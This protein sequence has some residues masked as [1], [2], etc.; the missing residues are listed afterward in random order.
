M[1][2][3]LTP[4][5]IRVCPRNIVG[6]KKC[7]KNPT[8]MGAKKLKSGLCGCKIC[9]KSTFKRLFLTKF[10]FS[11][12]T[13]IKIVKIPPLWVQKCPKPHPYACFQ[14]LS[15]PILMVHLKK[16][17]QVHSGGTSAE[18]RS[19]EDT[20]PQG[21]SQTTVFSSSVKLISKR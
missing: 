1:W 16:K 13:F 18:T 19:T 6:A 15:N 7:Q 17:K 3:Y 9:R 12:L 21:H 2:G 5:W 20:P 8:L 4:K 10:E 11:V 14:G